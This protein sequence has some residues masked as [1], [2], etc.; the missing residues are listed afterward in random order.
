MCRT[1]LHEWPYTGIY[2]ALYHDGGPDCHAD[3]LTRV[4]SYDDY[5]DILSSHNRYNTSISSQRCTM[6]GS[7]AL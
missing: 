3:S 2:G 7:D 1:G 6:Y 4:R 5:A